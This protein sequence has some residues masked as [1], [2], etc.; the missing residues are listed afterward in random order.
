MQVNLRE[1]LQVKD[2]EYKELK[3][4]KYQDKKNTIN[5][6]NKA[7]FI[8]YKSGQPRFLNTYH[9]HALE[10]YAILCQDIK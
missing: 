6:N 4:G 7:V 8:F 3:K 5:L 2:S 9:Y 10:K 1:H